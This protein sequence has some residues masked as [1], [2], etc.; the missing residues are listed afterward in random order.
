V[1]TEAAR[2]VLA[3]YR[4]PGNV[5]ELE[6]VLE[7]AAILDR[8]GSID[9]DDLPPALVAAAPA[10]VVPVELAGSEAGIDLAASVARYEW[11]LI[12]RAMRQAGGNKSR[13]AALLGIGRTTLIDKLKRPR[14]SS[15]R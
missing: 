3:L 15:D 11:A 12:D 14:S 7:R 2:V 6:N 8:D 4:W 5:R 9:A 1:V 13:A 10:A